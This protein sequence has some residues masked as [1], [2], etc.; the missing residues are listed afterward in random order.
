MQESYSGCL[1]NPKEFLL[2]TIKRLSSNRILSIS[3]YGIRIYALNLKENN[4]YSLIL[5]ETHLEGIQE[6]YEINDKNF[7]FFI[8]KHYGASMGGPS[9]DYL[10]I[11][12][13]EL[14]NITNEEK[15][16]RIESEENNSFFFFLDGDKNEGREKQKKEEKKKLFLL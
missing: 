14:K 8:R 15:K 4:C 7:F 12:K 9:H 2:L 11:E 16:Q 1:I 10:I 5:M 3:N 6:I 13:V